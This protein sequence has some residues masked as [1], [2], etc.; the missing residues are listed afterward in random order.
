MVKQFTSNMGLFGNDDE[1]K[2][3]DLDCSPQNEYASEEAVAKVDDIVDPG[4]KVHFLARETGGG[5]DVEAAGA[6]LFGGDGTRILGTIGDVRTA[7]T[8]RRVL[9]KIPLV[10]GSDVRSIP[11]SE[12]TGVDLDL[13]GMHR[14]LSVRT[15]ERTY[16]VDVGALPS[17]E[18]REMAAFVRE[19]RSEERDDELAGEHDVEPDGEPDPD[20]DMDSDAEPDPDA[21]AGPDMVEG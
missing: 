3:A 15:A 7:A 13:K 17:E 6:G 8:D 5:V 14:R 12:V 16:H 20:A 2:N 1:V 9:V 18:C 11:Y 10:L 4:E 19:K 21:D